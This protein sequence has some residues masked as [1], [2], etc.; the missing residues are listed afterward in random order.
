MPGGRPPKNGGPERYPELEELAEWLRQAMADAGYETPN[1][2]V[3][4]EIVPRNVVYGIHNATH[5]FRIEAVRALAAGLRKDPAAVEPLWRRAKEAR[6]RASVA[7]EA[8]EAP[9]LTSWADIP[10]PTLAVRNLTEAQSKSVE[11]LP[12]D[13]LGVEEPPLSAVYVRQRVRPVARDTAGAPHADVPGVDGGDPRRSSAARAEEGSGP[14]SVTSASDALAD[15]E[16]LLIT[17]EPGAGKSTLSSHLA[18]TLS[19]VWMGEESSLNAP[20]DEPVVPVR[21]AARTLVDQSGSW[22]AVLCQAVRRSLGRSLV[23]DPDPALFTGRVMG[24]RWLVLVDGLDEIA[25]REAR[26]AV[27]RTIAQ[28]ARTG[29]DYRFVITSRPLPEAELAPLRGSLVGAYGME[30]FAAAE[31]RDFAGKWFA[32]QYPDRPARARS[33]ADRFLK[34]TEDGRLHELVQNPLLATLAAVNATV[35]PA[36][37]LP[38]SRLSLYQRFCEHLLTRGDSGTKARTALRRR[39]GD[40]PERRDFHLWLDDHKREL[41]GV[42]GRCRLEGEGS[43]AEAALEWLRARDGERPR[44]P[45][46]ENEVAEFLQGTGLLVTEEDDYRFLHHSFAEFIAAQSYA[47][48]IAPDFPEAEVWIR[49]AFNGDERTLAL[50][51]FCM[52]SERPECEAD[53]IAEH[54][55]TGASGGHERPLLAG[56]LLAE[57]VPFGEPNRAAVLDRLEAIGRNALDFE[58]REKAFEVLGALG[59]LP[60][61]L[62]R[63][64]RIASAETLEAGCRLFAVEAFSSAGRAETAERLLRDVL[65]RIHGMLPHAS[66]VA[67]A[68]GDGAREAVRERCWSLAEEPDVDCY[69]LSRAVEALEAL[70]FR[71]DTAQMARRVLTMPWAGPSDLE[72][73]VEAWLKAK[74]AG[75]A[76]EVM[77]LTG[78][79]AASDQRG[80]S[81]VAKALEKQGQSEAAARLAAEVLR[82]P[83]LSTGRACE[84][85]QTLVRVRGEAARDDVLAAFERSGADV[86]HH[87]WLAARLLDTVTGLGGTEELME[88]VERIVGDHR[89]GFLGS[90]YAVAVWLKIKGAGAVETLME[91]TGRGHGLCGMD[92]AVMAGALLDAGAREEAGELAALALRTPNMTR[93]YYRDAA[94]V[95]L[96]TEGKEAAPLLED[97]WREAQGLAI[98]SDWLR[99]TLDALKAHEDPATDEAVCRL[100]RELVALP[101]AKSEDVLRG[102]RILA[103]V[104]GRFAVPYL[105]STAESHPVLGWFS[106]G[107][108]AQELAAMCESEAARKLWR[109][110]LALPQPPERFEL[111]LLDDMLTA[112]EGA[113]AATWLRELIE[114]PE[115][116]GPRR[117]HLRGLLAYLE[118]TEPQSRAGD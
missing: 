25:D 83:V 115:T 60:G 22:S 111:R 76:T 45:G 116:Y 10:V 71:D 15:H 17:G 47:G 20:L 69:R 101:T 107:D 81:A 33:A 46:W 8:A 64:E 68:L 97:I 106:Y 89:W 80:R 44:L 91:L 108:L 11:R 29:S 62:G 26:T 58:D 70:G 39:Y 87:V 92:R 65:P 6:D 112:G 109:A 94:A 75:A 59:R 36:R 1:A 38:T 82:A 13:M 85:A 88:R 52:W 21:I 19:R 72:R 103:T 34:E 42:L 114:D 9:R 12:Y 53:R 37:P 79:R 93:P 86:G 49:R 74:G 43:L 90:G 28:H 102:L 7:R 16:H 18:W 27:I 3:R 63:L 35:D 99:A 61:V 30:P 104:E 67:C 110:A 51:V 95:L 57:G 48:L 55:L 2:L 4:A 40:D 31:L 105:V 54:L 113:L 84:A 98:D 32:A 56:L 14:D 66:R 96:K 78:A 23:A 5:F 77:E 41:L 50:F 24:A 118:A 73:A 100:A 117:L